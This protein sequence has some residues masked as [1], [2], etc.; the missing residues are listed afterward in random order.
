VIAFAR[1]H[2]REAVIV[3]VAR[4]LAP[5]TQAGRVWPRMDE[6]EGSLSLQGLTVEGAGSRGIPLSTL[7]AS[8]PVTILKAYT[9]I[10]SK[11]MRQRITV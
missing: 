8:L 7:F 2:G 5:F 9:A 3:A 6:L 11:R 10:A 4:C 1:R